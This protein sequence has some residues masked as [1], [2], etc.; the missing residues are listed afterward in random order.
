MHAG[1]SGRRAYASRPGVR[2]LEGDLADGLLVAAS[3]G[4]GAVIELDAAKLERDALP[5]VA[6]RPGARLQA[7]G[8]RDGPGP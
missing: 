7:P 4:L 1:A 2:S 6:G 5:A 3:A 8:E